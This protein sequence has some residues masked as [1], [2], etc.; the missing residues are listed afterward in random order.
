[1]GIVE[2]I[3]SFV[4]RNFLKFGHDDT[5]FGSGISE[6]PDFLAGRWSRV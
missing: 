3:F 6:I 4:K 2:Q 1:M 5:S